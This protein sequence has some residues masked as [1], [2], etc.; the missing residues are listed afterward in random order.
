MLLN[1]GCFI[2]LDQLD[3]ICSHWELNPTTMMCRIQAPKTKEEPYPDYNAEETETAH[4]ISRL[5]NREIPVGSRRSDQ[6]GSEE[7]ET[8][9]E[10]GR[11]EEKLSSKKEARKG[12]EGNTGKE[13]AENSKEGQDTNSGDDG[14]ESTDDATDQPRRNNG[15]DA[16]SEREHRQLGKSA[17]KS[18]KHDRDWEK[19]VTI[20]EDGQPA[21]TSTSY[22]KRRSD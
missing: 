19:L 7:E 3:N 17:N 2:S 20:K 22:R 4:E 12:R 13:M 16:H 18:T 1:G 8:S 10:N 5:C 9:S 14:Y 11:Q 15:N 21:I 6:S